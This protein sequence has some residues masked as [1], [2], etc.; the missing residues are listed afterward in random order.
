M[1]TF[2]VTCF[3]QHRALQHEVC[4]VTTAKVLAQPCPIFL[5]WVPI[6]GRCRRC[7]PLACRLRRRQRRPVDRAR[8]PTAAASPKHMSP[9]ISGRGAPNIHGLTCFGEAAII[10]PGA[11]P[12]GRHV[13]FWWPAP[14]PW[15]HR[16]LMGPQPPSTK[17][18][19]DSHAKQPCDD[20]T[21]PASKS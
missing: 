21:I 13:L 8:G 2:R 5:D 20:I 17:D 11:P 6:W 18:S 15:N 3:V 1:D 19:T 16:K 12:T 9:C 7:N 4:Q 14:G 10:R